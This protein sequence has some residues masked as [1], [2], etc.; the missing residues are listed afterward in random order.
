VPVDPRPAVSGAD[1]AT[2]DV[3]AKKGKKKHKKHAKRNKG[4]HRK[5]RRQ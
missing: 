2:G 3:T 4:K 1:P 5:K